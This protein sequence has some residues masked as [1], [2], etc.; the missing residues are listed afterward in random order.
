MVHPPRS[1]FPTACW[2]SGVIPSSQPL[3]NSFLHS[4]KSSLL[5]PPDGLALRSSLVTLPVVDPCFLK[6]HSMLQPWS[7]VFLGGGDRKLKPE[8][9]KVFSNTSV[10]IAWIHVAPH[11]RPCVLVSV[12]WWPGH[13]CACKAQSQPTTHSLSSCVHWCCLGGGVSKGGLQLTP[14]AH[15]RGVQSTQGAQIKEQSP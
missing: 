12:W 2:T 4:S 8:A 11:I 1:S 5:H 14:M 13:S 10:L 15:G 7:P 9:L 6:P 3:F